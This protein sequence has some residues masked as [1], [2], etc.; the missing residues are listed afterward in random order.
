VL[1]RDLMDQ[2][3]TAKLQLTSLLREPSDAD[4]QA[5]QELLTSLEAE[6]RAL[7]EEPAAAPVHY[8][9][10]RVWTERLGDPQSAATCYQ[11]AY[12][13]DPKYRPNLEAA[14]RL[15][16]A[17]ASWERSLAL[18]QRE[19]ATLKD[20][21]AKA[22]SMRAQARLLQREL[23]RPAEAAALIQQALALSPDHPAL[24]QAAVDAASSSGDQVLSVKLLLRSAAAL[25]DDVQKALLLR[26]A[27]LLLEVL[28]QEAA[29]RQGEIGPPVHNADGSPL[30]GPGELD[31]M[32]QEALRRLLSACP[33]DPIALSGLVQRA[34]SQG[35]WDELLTLSRAQAERTGAASDRLVAASV[36]AHKLSRT[37][38]ALEDV[39]A[40]LADA[41]QD[42]ALLALQCDL[43]AAA[44]PKDL[45]AALAARALASPEASE[46]AD[47]R[48]VAATYALAPLDR[49]QL[50]SEALAENPGDAAAIA[51]H[52]RL[53]A[54]RD[55][56]AA[57]ERFAALG[58]ALEGHSADEAAAFAAEAALWF[59]RAGQREQAAD[60]ARRAL[61]QVP[62]QPQALRVLERQLP[63][64]GAQSELAR[65]LEEAA[66]SAPRWQGAELLSR[67]AALLSDLPAPAQLETEAAASDGGETQTLEIPPAAR[68]LELAQ[69]A[70]ELARGLTGPR[71]LEAW[72]LLSL[73]CS[74]ASSLGKSLEA[75]AA[76]A[77]G[78]EAAELL[79]EA[80][81]LA[82]VTGDDARA[83]ALLRRAQ[84]ADPSAAQV[85]RAMLLLPSLPV[86]ERLTLLAEEASAADPH[87]A[88]ALHAERA[89]LLEAEGHA[90]E[91]VS[92][93]ANALATGGADLA[94]LRRL[95]R[96]QLRRGE[97][98]AALAILVQIAHGSGEETGPSRADAFCRAAEVAEWRL[99]DLPR[100]EELYSEAARAFPGSVHAQAARVRL[101]CWL[102]RWADAA[103]AAEELS[104]VSS[105]VQKREA[106][107]MA[108]T[109][110]AFRTEEPKQAE[111]LFRQ[112][113]AEEPG[114]L[115]A[116]AALLWL[117]R[118]SYAISSA[119]QARERI[120]L[121]GKLASRCQDPRLA[122][123]L[124][125]ESAEDRLAAGERDQGIAEYRRALALNPHDR[126]AL[127]L[128]EDALRASGQR[129][130]LADHLAFRCAYEDGTTR[131]ALSL[132]QAELFAE[133]GQLEKAATAYR[134]ALS[135]DPSSLLAVRGARKIA[136][137]MGDK[138][139]VMR[140]LS[141]EA[142]L[143]HDPGLA[144]GS[145]IE[146]ALLAEDLGD[147]EQALAHLTSV[148]DRDPRNEEVAAS[149]RRLHGEHG[150]QEL[151]T[152]FERIGATHKEKTAGAYAWTRAGRIQLD[153]LQDA[154]AAF[155]S[156]GRGLK[157]FA[158][159]PE[160]LELRADAGEVAG[161]WA[162]AA[163][164]L[165]KR[166]A[167]SDS[168]AA[169]LGGALT[170]P[171]LK[172][173]LGK[174][175]A[176]KLDAGEKA[177]PLL[178][179]QIDQVAMGTLAKLAP[180]AR[181]L[182]P[183]EATPIYR[184]LLEGFPVPSQA[185]NETA[186]TPTK[187]QIAEWTDE[188]GRGCL[189]LGE[190]AEA[191]AAFRRAF[192]L[193]PRNRAAL[194]HVAE[195]T[196]E[197]NPLEAIAVWRQ[198]LELS[199]ARA[200]PLH[201]LVP[202][203]TRTGRSDAAFCAAATLVGLAD[204]NADERAVHEAIARLP[205]AA[206][207]PQLGD[208]PALRGLGDEGAVRDLLL[209][210]APELQL[211]F[212]TELTGRGER[213]KGDNP[214]RRV[215]AALARALGQ[216]EPALY[217]SKTE[218]EVVAP[219][220]GE[221]PGLLVGLEAP[222]RYPPRLQRFLYARSLA[223]LRRGTH[224]LASWTA[225]RLGQ[226]AGALV[227]LCAP[228][229]TDGSRLPVPDAKLLE[230]LGKALSPEARTRL[231]PLAQQAAAETTSFEQLAL[232]L[233]ESAERVALVLCG[234]PAAGLSMVSLEC[235]G[236]LDRPE[237]ARLARFAVSET[238]LGL[239]AR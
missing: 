137:A 51:L 172:L 107:R 225:P 197:Q 209:A 177:L 182:P 13:L 15:F 173:R 236:G 24:L 35:A 206:E 18:H 199:P 55:P 164:A 140:L 71:W 57:A 88:A 16:A 99:H 109:L 102:G 166:L 231:A 61:T 73:R 9:M 163:D 19:A 37:T 210:A 237:V 170:A 216:A 234:D 82:R 136:E 63:F 186:G 92:A 191:L 228:P 112:L 208:L 169:P 110:R 49:E 21:A 214:V 29:N 103:D 33:G 194:Q 132:Q 189:A 202:L 36:A 90:D 11:N 94:V 98:E 4:V 160:A 184:K 147:S 2:I 66:A 130:L 38:E 161:R 232:G 155:I 207:V 86:A 17:E 41:P 75:R 239:R 134:Q 6:A 80:G 129:Q 193:E 105:K 211:A 168:G 7:G 23:H 70:T 14:R 118:G 111:G 123:L 215:C 77:P 176:E 238:F 188:L 114:D 187:A 165:S 192:Q 127:D 65:L 113:L 83:A 180:H 84:K 217:L 39:R 146:A 204:A 108:A 124:R 139:E 52:S 156:A 20:P 91:A 159:L 135:S 144:A 201:A 179:G 27:V 148:L 40:A 1:Y 30:P 69:R 8:A 133:D 198:L 96:L 31:Q 218:P 12:D 10:G 125:A 34:R 212:P 26:R 81:E 64:L 126:V 50:L 220:A 190:K 233:R 235:P 25:K 28:Q 87:R 203:F 183:P 104:K 178:L 151:V 43:V 100:A 60:R 47:L 153:E 145:L 205:P 56:A 121:R 85:R 213:V 175:Y 76:S 48:I 131:A 221:A 128:V 227:Q 115:D 122:A 93:C 222:R 174:L 185:P 157:I 195:L 158:D 119:E 223:H 72:T 53:V 226:L 22:E 141:K 196:G 95:A 32:L 167:L 78:N 44:A 59:E 230:K 171:V 138:G 142:S 3:V 67:A 149:L 162:D 116:M 42:A 181:Q 45:P 89:A 97:L 101:R 74:D 229:G 219:V 154:Q 143:S 152:L 5:A 58:E 46:R 54:G 150:A 117:T 62:N 79:L 106:L 68:A 120:E 200:E 224:V